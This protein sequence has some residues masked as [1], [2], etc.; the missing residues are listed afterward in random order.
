MDFLLKIQGL[1]KVFGGLVAVNKVDLSVERGTRHAIIGPNGA[2]KSVL[3]GMISGLLRPTEGEINFDGQDITGLKPDAITQKGIGRTFQN[4]RVFPGMTVMEN[5]MLGRHCRSKA[6]LIY[7]FLRPPFV[8]NKKEA[9]MREKVI[10]LLDDVG[11]IDKANLWASGLNLVDQRRLEFARALATQPKLLLL[12]E[13]TS[14]MGSAESAVVG[15][16][17]NRINKNGV[18][19]LFIAHDI[20][21]IM[22][23]A[24]RVTAL[25]FGTKIAEGLPPQVR[26]NPQVLEAYL[27][28]ED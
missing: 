23:L 1:T 25:N 7:T 18:T 19:V 17:I 3:L 2:G 21:L 20:G 24:H 22:G 26:D 4:I 13:P 8:Q 28:T 6:D 9:E 11:L 27:G 16:L 5:V 14:G 12:D 10:G 15:D